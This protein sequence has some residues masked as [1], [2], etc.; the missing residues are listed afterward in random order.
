MANRLSIHNIP[1]IPSRRIGIFGILGIQ[2]FLTILLLFQMDLI[3][4]I[5]PSF[6]NIPGIRIIWN[7]RIPNFP[8]IPN[9]PSISNI[10]NIPSIP[11]ILNNPY[12]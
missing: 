9:I 1:N 8:M 3:F 5:I 4:P 7:T 6:L 12:S 10:A 11:N 2:I